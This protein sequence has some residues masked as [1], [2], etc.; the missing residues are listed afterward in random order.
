MDARTTRIVMAVLFALWAGIVLRT[1]MNTKGPDDFE[2]TVTQQEVDA[3]AREQLAGLQA[4][5]FAQR[6]ELCG[7]IFEDSEGRLDTT[8]LLEGEVASCDIAYFDEPGMAPVASYH[9]H[10]AYDRDY[11]SEVP[12]IQDF[13]SDLESGMDGYVSTPGGRFWRVDA[14][15]EVAI[16]LCG[17]GCL[18][19]DPGY[20]RCDGAQPARRFTLAELGTWFDRPEANC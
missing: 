14:D 4:R 11:D 7:V 16:Q 12:S 9:T 3:F 5:S 19:Q 6:T 13:E 1:V 10:G 8:P 18:Q 17:P 20:Q 2:I 15:E